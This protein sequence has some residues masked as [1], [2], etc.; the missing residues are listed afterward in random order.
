M[1]IP[2]TDFMFHSND[3][4][5]FPSHQLFITSWDGRPVHVHQFNRETSFDMRRYQ[6]AELLLRMGYLTYTG[7]FLLPLMTMDTG[8]RY[9]S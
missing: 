7:I 5:P 9:Q 3:S 2:V 6:Y 8:M 1:G 4:D